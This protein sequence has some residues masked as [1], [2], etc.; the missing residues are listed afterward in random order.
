ML[1]IVAFPYK[2]AWLH[3]E[4]TPNHDIK[5]FIVEIQLELIT[6]RHNFA[7]MLRLPSHTFGG[8]MEGICGNCN[9]IQEDDL[10]KQD[11]Q[12]ILY[13]ATLLGKSLYE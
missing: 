7:F 3:I 13:S 5:L 6:Y 4:E 12:V 8:A 2:T 1:T 11:G 9:G 10:K